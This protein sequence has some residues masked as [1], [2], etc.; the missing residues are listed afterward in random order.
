MDVMKYTQYEETVSVEGAE[1]NVIV[2][3][4]ENESYPSQLIIRSGS[5]MLNITLREFEAIGEV[6]HRSLVQEGWEEVKKEG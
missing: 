6:V 4:P 3:V 2:Q 5:K 1:I